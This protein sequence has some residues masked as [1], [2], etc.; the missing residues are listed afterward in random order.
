MIISTGTYSIQYKA[1]TPNEEPTID[2]TEL[3]QS[4]YLSSGSL[5]P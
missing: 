1:N 2:P 3:H 5:K 4:N